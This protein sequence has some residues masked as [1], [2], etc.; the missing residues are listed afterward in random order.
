MGY[1]SSRPEHIRTLMQNVH[2]RYAQG[3]D[4]FPKFRLKVEPEELP[5]KSRHAAGLLV[6]AWDRIDE[7]RAYFDETLD[8]MSRVGSG[9]TVVRIGR[10]AVQ[11]GFL[12]REEVEPTVDLMSTATFEELYGNKEFVIRDGRTASY[13]EGELRQP[14]TDVA[15]AR[16]SNLSQIM[17]TEDAVT[18]LA[19]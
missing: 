9:L 10:N 6:K 8:V 3:V 19:A 15:I 17:L 14:G 4:L 2:D 5:R 7:D 13:V 12:A 18:R 1:P 11:V 16:G